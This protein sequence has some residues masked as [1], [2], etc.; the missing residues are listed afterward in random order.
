MRKLLLLISAV[1]VT[2]MASAQLPEAIKVSP[3]DATPFTELTLT[4][5]VSKSCPQ[6]ALFHADS[7]MIHSGV[8]IDGSAWQNV[9]DFDAMGANG[10][11]AKLMRVGPGFPAAITLSPGY[12][13][14]SDEVTLTLDT[15]LSCPDSALFGVDSVMMHSGITV[16]GSAW[17]M[18]VDFDGE[19]ANG[20]KPKMTNNGD[21]TWS[22]TFIPAEF[23]GVG[24]DDT[25]TAINAVFNAGSWDNEGKDFDAEGNCTDFTIPIG[26]P[27][28]FH[29]A[30]TYTPSEYYDFDETVTVTEINCVFNGGAWD[31][32]EGK[33]FDTEMNCTDFVI[34]LSQL[35]I[36]ENEMARYNLYPNPVGE[37]LT[38][39]LYNDVDRIEVYNAIGSRVM[40]FENIDTELFLINTSDL[41]PGVFFLTVWKNDNVH[42]SKFVKK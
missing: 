33:D 42:T 31:A 22:I 37:E 25:V 15:R 39:E 18:V 34:P 32:G 21:S 2:A 16:N 30:I 19:G 4:L 11:S 1:M 40:S 9:V 3:A 10:Q 35:S 28:A 24:A 26:V 27:E 38:I 6:D 12:V 13:M 5:D 41:N 17:Q 7:V 36:G 14:A 8:N 23:Y 20:Q 29:W